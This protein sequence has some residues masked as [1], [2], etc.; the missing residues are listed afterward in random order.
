MGQNTLNMQVLQRKTSTIWIS[1]FFSCWIK[2]NLKI[3][4]ICRLNISTCHGELG[5]IWISITQY[6]N[7]SLNNN[8][9]NFSKSPPEAY[10]P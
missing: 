3:N 10:I 7:T 1:S 8:G 6:G 4:E 5:D 2:Q 9:K